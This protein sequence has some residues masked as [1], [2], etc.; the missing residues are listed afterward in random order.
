MFYDKG[1]QRWG[2]ASPEVVGIK[3]A[4]FVI[5]VGWPIVPAVS[6]SQRQGCVRGEGGGV[7]LERGG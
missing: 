3:A 2:P 7:D 4:P 1:K 6:L 5:M